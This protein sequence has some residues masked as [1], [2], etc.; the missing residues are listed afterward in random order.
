MIAKESLITLGDIEPGAS[1][2]RQELIGKIF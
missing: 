2:R 1:L